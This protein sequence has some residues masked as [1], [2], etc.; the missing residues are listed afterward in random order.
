MKAIKFN[1][2]HLFI[3]IGVVAMMLYSCHQR[4]EPVY[5]YSD[6]RRVIG[7]EGGVINFFEYNPE[8]SIPNVILKMEFPQGALDSLVVFNMYEFYDDQTYIDLYLLN[9]IQY[10][11]F[12]YLIPFYESFGY[13]NVDTTLQ[14][15]I[16]YHLSI[17]FNQPVKIT[18]KIREYG[19]DPNAKLYRIPIPKLNDP[20]WDDNVWVNWN[21][22]GYADGYY[23]LDLVYL[24]TGRW[25]QN[26]PWGTGTPSLYNWEE[27]PAESYTYNTSDSTVT[28]NINNTDYIYSMGSLLVK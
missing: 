25:T 23:Q 10:S 9:L 28:F 19:Y 1:K 24:I 18:Y 7:P 6:F 26:D 22:Q 4:Y 16:D 17:N 5:D 11:D 21:N 2:Y 3:I 27:L 13:N 14:D 20:A 8:D 15:E 12:L